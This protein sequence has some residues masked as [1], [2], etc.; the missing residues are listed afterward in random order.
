VHFDSS[1]TVI[2][3]VIR[4]NIDFQSFSGQDVYVKDLYIHGC[5][6]PRTYITIYFL[7]MPN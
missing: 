6:A 5:Q 3:N 2:E 4:V 7:Q 1:G